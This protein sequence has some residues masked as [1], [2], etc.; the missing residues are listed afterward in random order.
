M[1]LI[2]SSA[3][4]D[5]GGADLASAAEAAA[6]EA[7]NDHKKWHAC[8]KSMDPAALERLWAADWLPPDSQG[9]RRRWQV[10]RWLARNDPPAALRVLQSSSGTTPDSWNALVWGWSERDLDGAFR[11]VLDWGR[12]PLA[13]A[14]THAELAQVVF[15]VALKAK[16]S[17]WVGQNIHQLESPVQYD[18]LAQ[19]T[20]NWAA[21][22]GA[23][24]CQWL[25][26]FQ[27]GKSW[28]IYVSS[29]FAQWS[30]Q[31]PEKSWAVLETLQGEG[32]EAA[33]RGYA[34]GIMMRDVRDGIKFLKDLQASGRNLSVLDTIGLECG[35][36]HPEKGFAIWEAIEADADADVF[37]EAFLQRLAQK[38]PKEAAELLTSV[39][40]REVRIRLADDIAQ[41]WHG[42]KA[43]DAESWVASLTDP[44]LQ[45]A[46]RK[47][48]PGPAP[49][50]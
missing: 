8:V 42:K 46:A 10:I 15:D 3:C 28:P 6:R 5:A 24:A 48:L 37:A 30:R 31:D 4:M 20:W 7:A 38:R 43:Q 25:L 49:S 21:L 12:H 36:L 1:L 17:A 11:F 16:N 35:E 39:H 23:Q 45:A 13:D 40:S 41:A 22:D 47:G 18:A 32:Y 34:R 14:P 2:A 50:P 9:I 19:F 44:E 26:Q 33:A 29:G 27:E